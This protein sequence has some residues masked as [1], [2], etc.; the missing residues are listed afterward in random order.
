[1]ERE[2]ERREMERDKKGVGEKARWRE[3]KKN[4]FYLGRD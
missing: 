1:M 2:R 3:F 4:N